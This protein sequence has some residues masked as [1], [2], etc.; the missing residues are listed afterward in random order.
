VV[1]GLLLIWTAFGTAQSYEGLFEEAASLAARGDVSG[2]AARYEAALRLRPGAVEALSNLSVMYYSAERWADAETT[3]AQALRIQPKLTAANLIRGLSLIRLDRSAEAIA[4]LEAALAADPNNR[5]ALLGLGGSLVATGQLDKAAALYEQRIAAAPADAD[6]WY[7]LAVCYERRAEAAS[8]R[9]SQ[10]TTGAAWAKRFLGEYWLERG[11]WRL[12][13]EALAEA[14]ALD[15]RQP[16]LSE[17]LAVAEANRHW[18]PPSGQ[19]VQEANDPAGD[20]YRQAR[21][22]AAKSRAAFEKFTELAPSSWQ[23][24]L[25]LGDLHRQKRDFQAA[26]RH[27]QEA[28]RLRPDSPWALGMGTVYWELADDER[29][30]AHLERALASNPKSATALFALGNIAV[31]QH[32]NQEAV[33][34][35]ER[36]LRLEGG[37]LGARADLGKAYY[38]LERYAMAVPHLQAALRIDSYGDIHFQLGQTLRKLGRHEEAARALAESK[39]IR[40]AQ[41]AREQRLRLGH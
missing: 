2:A 32:R 37:R 35:L 28:G 8:R 19:P 6:A 12:A 11:E 38:R 41:L 16:G 34:L 36:C 21:A 39:R 7:A 5:D 33:E 27:Y 30:I 40:D 23:A 26:L 24:H 22:L 4:P 9:L 14:L 13:R 25:F 31:K 18:L 10:L 3:A 15:P 17:L 29:A 20:L 1:V